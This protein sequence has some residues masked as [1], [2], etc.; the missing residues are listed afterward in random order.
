MTMTLVFILII[1]HNTVIREQASAF[2]TL[3]G[4]L[5]EAESNQACGLIQF[6]QC[7]KVHTVHCLF[8]VGCVHCIKPQAKPP[9]G[10]AVIS[11]AIIKLWFSSD[12]CCYHQAM[13]QQ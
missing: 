2:S 3:Q 7:T 8:V 9:V 10:S 11:A 4:R 6:I 12:Q 1:E 5:A 13:V